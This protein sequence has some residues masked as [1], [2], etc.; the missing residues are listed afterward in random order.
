MRLSELPST[1]SFR[2]AVFFLGLFWGASLVLFAVLY[3]LTAGYMTTTVDSWLA[4]ESASF[5]AVPPTVLRQRLDAH[6]AINPDLSRPYTLFDRNGNRISGSSLTMPNNPIL[7]R[8]FEF[9]EMQNGDSVPYRGLMRR[10]PS[11]DYLL[12]AQNARK[13]HEMSRMMVNALGWGCLLMLVIG[14]TGAVLIGA[15][16][17]RR[18]NSV[19]NAIERIVKGNLTE[20]LPSRGRAGDLDCLIDVVNGMLDEIERLMLQVKGVSNDIAHDLRT[21]LT[22]LLAGLERAQ[23]RARSSEEFAAAVESATQEVRAVLN[24]FAALLRIA[25]IEDGARR[26]GFRSVDLNVIAAAATEFYG[27]LAEEKSVS[28]RLVR[29]HGAP[30]E[31][32]GDDHLLSEALDNLIENAI[33]FTP[34]GSQVSV[35]VTRSAGAIGLCVTDQGAGIPAE[36]REKVL[37]R[38]Y[39]GEKSRN[40]SGTGLGLCLVAAVAQLHALHLLIEDADPGCRV[41]LSTDVLCSTVRSTTAEARDI[42]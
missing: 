24:T 23:R 25:E 16:T 19:T 12:I 15:G 31:I 27:P 42:R 30:A 17:I 14:L 2:L 33:K 29:C 37:R 10:L 38:F 8:P 7:G 41:S 9:S 11:G 35:S 13:L 26:R 28:L 36:E 34:P 22:R 3:W 32:L 39:R 5:L 40:T 21:P 6:I 20:R 18:I 4:R 1:T